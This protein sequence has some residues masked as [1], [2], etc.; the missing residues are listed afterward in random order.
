[1]DLLSSLLDFCGRS[2]YQR[3]GLNVEHRHREF[4]VPPSGVLFCAL[5]IQTRGIRPKDRI[6]I[7]HR[8]VKERGMLLQ[9]CFIFGCILPQ[10]AVKECLQIALVE[11]QAIRKDKESEDNFPF[12]VPAFR[13]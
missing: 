2:V 12:L 7:L 3:G 1:M 13:L 6:D 4:R 9:P 8:L 10:V 11:R 5:F